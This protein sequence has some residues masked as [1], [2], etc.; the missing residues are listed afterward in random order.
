MMAKKRHAPKQIIHKRREAEVLTERWRLHY[1]RVRPHSV[2]G[3]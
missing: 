1:N 2:L 3:Y